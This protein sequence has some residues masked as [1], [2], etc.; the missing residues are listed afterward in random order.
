MTTHHGAQASARPKAPTGPTGDPLMLAKLDMPQLPPAALIRPRLQER[1]TTGVL[2][3]LTSVCAPPGAGKTTLL[4]SWVSAEVAPG[5]V[6][7][8]NLDALD[9]QPGIF[10]SYLLTGLARAGVPT[11]TVAAP[12]HP[13]RLD[14]SF[15]WNLS[16]TLYQRS[17]PLVVVLD[18]ADVLGDSPVCLQLDFLLRNSG[19]ALRLVVLTRGDSAVPLSRYRLAGTVTEVRAADLAAT[20]EEAKALF[21]QRDVAISAET[22][23][24]LMSRTRGWMAGLVLTGIALRD[25]P[26]RERRP[27]GVARGSEDLDEYLDDEVLSRYTP[28]VRRFLVRMSVADHVPAGL[29]EELTGQPGAARLLAELAGHDD[30]LTCCD[31][32]TDCYL[33]HPLLQDVLRARLDEESPGSAPQ[34]HRRASAWF[35]AAGQ[36]TEAAVHAA[37]AGEW[38]TAARLLVDGLAVPQLLA[39]SGSSRLTW[40]LAD[41]PAEIP[42]AEAAVVRAAVALGRR[43]AVTC[44][45]QLAQARE[46]A[47]QTPELASAVALSACAVG[48][49]L[50]AITGDAEARAVQ[51][52]PCAAAGR[53]HGYG[54][55]LPGRGGVDGRARV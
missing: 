36:P 39:G 52:G 37:A 2:G 12:S 21:A 46:L 8:I 3:R 24:I 35:V 28:S 19:P 9:R 25:R 17:E 6:V 54:S 47:G 20:P 7:W 45:A 55:R 51:H 31:Q 4:L 23:D 16:A 50:A 5:P 11:S 34:L 43:D 48:S 10:W 33:Y 42:G 15:L 13:Y 44:A 14:S 30:F 18:D 26:Q 32:H 1:I 49:G 41:L 29:A 40:L 27:G 22:L 53:P 38:R